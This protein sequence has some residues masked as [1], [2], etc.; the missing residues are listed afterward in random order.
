[1]DREYDRFELRVKQI[2]NQINDRVVACEHL[3]VAGRAFLKV[4]PAIN[5]DGWRALVDGLDLQ[6]SSR[7]VNGLGFIIRTTEAELPAL[8]AAARADGTPDYSVHPEG[9]RPGYC[10]VRFIEP[11]SKPRA[12]RLDSIGS[13]KRTAK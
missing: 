13:M 10:A 9:S 3:M 8:L 5:R 7:G 11:M 12:G 6:R 2:T 4:N 1:M